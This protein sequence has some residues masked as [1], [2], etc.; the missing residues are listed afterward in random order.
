[1][2]LLVKRVKRLRKKLRQIAAL[3]E[4][5]AGGAELTFEE[6]L[7][8]E[9]QETFERELQHHLDQLEA[10]GVDVD[11]VF[12]E[13]RQRKEQ[14]QRT[15]AAA[16]KKQAEQERLAAARSAKST[17]T[18]AA[19]SVAATV[20]P[21]AAAAASVPSKAAAQPRPRKS[22]A[23]SGQPS[24]TSHWQRLQPDVQAEQ[25][26]AR[27]RVTAMC[28]L[29]QSAPAR[30]AT[31]GS[32][33][34]SIYIW[35]L[36]HGNRQL[37]ALTGH[38]RSVTQLVALE[39]ERKLASGS[40]DCKILLWDL[41][42]YRQLLEIYTYA[43]VSDLV[44]LG[45]DGADLASGS[46]AGKIQVWKG[47]S[48]RAACTEQAFAFEVT[49]LALDDPAAEAPLLA[50]G[51]GLGAVKVFRVARQPQYSLACIL[52]VSSEQPER[53]RSLHLASAARLVVWGADGVNLRYVALPLAATTAR[54]GAP[55]APPI[56]YAPHHVLGRAAPIEAMVADPARGLLLASALNMTHGRGVVHIHALPGEAAAEDEAR[57]PSYQQSLVLPG[58][59][60]IH[61]MALAGDFLCLGAA[62]GHAVVLQRHADGSLSSGV[63]GSLQAPIQ[64]EPESDEDED[65]DGNGDEDE[66]GASGRPAAG[67]GEGASHQQQSWGEWAGSFCLLL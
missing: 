57:G 3:E 35:D 34:T 52:S 5:E 43:P 15:A 66:L 65:G 40:L 2:D 62:R 19:P 41:C 31:A 30:L 23:A 51:S 48:K 29:V 64:S 39:G 4:R 63:D 25:A 53:I 33:D 36:E 18:P 8:V 1:M 37:A 49:R 67:N 42:S 16:A 28:L 38:E 6:R 21:A 26:P 22:K 59:P 47:S 11:A 14:E 10:S 60:R 32:H 7:K 45:I 13:Q 24:S 56:Q 27:D 58:M 12:A 50:A 61:S 20:P 54:G 9:E 55:A 46:E 17:P 44:A